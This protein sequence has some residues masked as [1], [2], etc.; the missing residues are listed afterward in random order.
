MI[1]HLQDVRRPVAR[2]RS[3]RPHQVPV[4]CAVDVLRV[5][6]GGDSWSSKPG[7]VTCPD[8]LARIAT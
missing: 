7:L 2:K 3:G 6:E 4:I 5:V 1:V 8:C